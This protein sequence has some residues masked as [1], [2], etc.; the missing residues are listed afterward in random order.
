MKLRCPNCLGDVK[1]IELWRVSVAYCERCGWNVGFAAN[2]LRAHVR[3]YW[4]ASAVGVVLAMTAWRGPFGFSGFA[5]LSLPF[6]VLPVSMVFVARRYLSKL[7]A[8]SQRPEPQTAAAA[9]TFPTY[10]TKDPHQIW[11]EY[12]R[13]RNWARL[14][15]VALLAGLCLLIQ[16]HETLSLELSRLSFGLQIAIV[17]LIIG[18]ATVLFSIPMLRWAEWRCPRCGEKFAQPKSY[19]VW[20]SAFSILLVLTILVWRLIFQSSCSNCQ[21]RCGDLAI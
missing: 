4:G 15:L 5:M 7:S 1:K 3:G 21:L 2:A 20:I 18:I 19:S 10:S 14:T 13:N 12:Y 17:F 11:S 8:I 6:I 9:K 16:K